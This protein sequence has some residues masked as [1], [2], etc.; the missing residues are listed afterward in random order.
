MFSQVEE[1]SRNGES[2]RDVATKHKSE[3][4]HISDFEVGG[5]GPEIQR[6]CVLTLWKHKKT[7]KR[8]LL[9]RQASNTAL[10]TTLF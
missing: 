5:R 8:F 2:E 10:L 1:K 7:K 4:S 9:G 3:K 6:M